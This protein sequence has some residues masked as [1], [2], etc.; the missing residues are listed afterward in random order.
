M[1]YK[2]R[3]GDDGINWWVGVV[4]DRF[5][6]L[7]VGRC[8]VRVFGAHTDNLDQL[9]TSSLPWATVAYSPNSGRE[10]SA[11]M[12][13]DWVTGFFLDGESKQAPVITGIFMSIIQIPP[14]DAADGKGFNALAKYYNNEE[15]KKES[16]NNIPIVY[17]DTP[18]SKILRAANP[19]I[20][21]T[22]YE[23]KGTGIQKSDNNRAHVCDITNEIRLQAAIDFIKNL[24]IFRAARAAIEAASNGAA[25]S[26]IS[27]QI[28]EAIKCLRA[29]VQLIQYS[30]RIVNKFIND[31]LNVLQT[32]RAMITWLLSLPAYL[33]AMLQ[34]CLAELYNAVSNAV[35]YTLENAAGSQLI[36]EIKGLYGD[37]INTV[38]A[39]ITVE[40]N[41]EN[42]VNQTTNLINPKT[43]GRP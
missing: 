20:P 29:Y 3:L 35:G 1:N 14:E 26:P 4:E 33:L 22:A 17:S 18:A 9:P 42:A 28:I 38:E 40:A 39:A 23:Y 13:G 32:I 6:P 30:L 21:A 16:A 25:A 5:D 37:V 31:I 19:S 24:G 8:K 27:T 11:P 10:F 43:Y 34:D 15:A 12:E 2:N 7:N 36:S 41:A